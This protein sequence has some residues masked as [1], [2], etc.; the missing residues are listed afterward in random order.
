MVVRGPYPDGLSGRDG[1]TS[2]RNDGFHQQSTGGRAKVRLDTGN[3]MVFL[4]SQVFFGRRAFCEPLADLAANPVVGLATQPNS[5]VVVDDRGSFCGRFIWGD[6]GASGNAS[7]GSAVSFAGVCVIVWTAVFN[8]DELPPFQRGVGHRWSGSL[9]D[10]LF[11]I[12]P[13]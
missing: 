8:P 9:G 10:R 3:A 1:N 5:S 13:R 7:S 12:E 4:C 2:S 6:I 11:L